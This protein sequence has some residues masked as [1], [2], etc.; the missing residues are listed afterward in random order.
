MDF[1]LIHFVCWFVYQ[2][3]VGNGYIEV[4]TGDMKLWHKRY[5]YYSQHA[6]VIDISI[7]RPYNAIKLQLRRSWKPPKIHTKCYCMD[8]SVLFLPLSDVRIY[9]C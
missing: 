8:L 6:V 9:L 4:V 2:V 3:C 5:L 7:V 1:F